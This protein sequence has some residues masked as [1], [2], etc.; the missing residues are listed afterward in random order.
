MPEPQKQAKPDQTQEADGAH[1]GT[2]SHE[3]AR[4]LTEKA[5]G[6]FADG[7]ERQGHDLVQEAK[8]LDQSAVQEV[9]DE[10]EEDAG[11]DHTPTKDGA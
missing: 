10:L 4:D 11:S 2:D 5:L 6:A 9:L 3:K 7:D 1:D 8:Q